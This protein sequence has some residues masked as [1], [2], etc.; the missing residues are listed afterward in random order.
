MYHFETCTGFLVL[1]RLGI[2]A[3][4]ALLSRKDFEFNSS[5]RLGLCS[6]AIEASQ[7]QQTIIVTAPTGA[8]LIAP[9]SG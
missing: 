2:A 6:K 8:L 1:A 3:I 4:S 7:E 9:V 5:E